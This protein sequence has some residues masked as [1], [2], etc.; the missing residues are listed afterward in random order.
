MNL[1]VAKNL[2]RLRKESGYTQEALA[3]KVGVSRQA[4]SNWEKGISSPDTDNLIALA[5]LYGVMVDDIV[6]ETA[7]QEAF[8]KERDAF[9]DMEVDKTPAK[10][11]RFPA[12]SFPFPVLAVLVYF[13][14]SFT[15][16][17]WD[18][19]WII[20]LSI[21]LYYFAINFVDYTQGKSDRHWMSVFPYPIIVVAAFLLIGF[22]S[23]VWHPTWL[24][25]LTIPVYYFIVH[26][27][28]NKDKGWRAVLCGVFP[29]LIVC[30]YLLLGFSIEG[31]WKWAWLVF[32]TIPIWS[33]AFKS[34]KST[35]AA[36][37]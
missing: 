29:L 5:K 26:V 7:G 13:I 34:N 36:E 11:K 15:T 12:A 28:E 10:K 33:W 32:L 25:F 9:F 30:L 14:L 37:K 22:L 24:L 19:T 6:S 16:E 1:N 2:E 35:D 4:V 31:A 21:P 17:R 8:K 23:G 3:E 20:F 18:M 27:I